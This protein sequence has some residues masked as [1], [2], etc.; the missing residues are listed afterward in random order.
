MWDHLLLLLLSGFSCVWPSA[1]GWTAAFQAPPSMGFSRQE[2][3]AIA[4]SGIY[5]DSILKRRLCQQ[6]LSSQSYD[7]FSS[8]VWIWELD[9]KESWA[10]KNWYFWTVA[11]EKTLES[12]LDCKEIKPVHPKGNQSWIFIGRTDGWRWNSNFWPPDAKNRLLGKD[13]DAG[14]DW[15]LEE[16]H[17]KRLRC[18]DGITNS[19]DVSLSRLWELMM[20]REAWCAAVH[21]VAKS[22][23][24][25]SD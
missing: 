8:H 1:T 19:M 22:R 20:D 12:P 24:W 6:P 25:L 23:T 14:K 11:L 18:L 4:F 7:F 13:P 2:W 3:G 17:M 5:L 10:L 9:Y 16:K 21:G 15:R